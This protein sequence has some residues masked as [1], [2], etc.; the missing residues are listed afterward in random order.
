MRWQIGAVQCRKEKVITGQG[1]AG[2]AKGK[3][4]TRQKGARRGEGAER[5]WEGRE[6]RKERRGKIGQC[7]GT[8][9]LA[10]QGGQGG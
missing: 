8:K 1:R 6:G 7:S 2:Q 3:G 4:R 10:E 9:G 5:T